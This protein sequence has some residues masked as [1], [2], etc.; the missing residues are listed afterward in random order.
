MTEDKSEGRR[1][2]PAVWEA[3]DRSDAKQ[4]ALQYQSWL[5]EALERDHDE[6]VLK[7]ARYKELPPELI[8]A[9]AAGIQ[10][11][12][13][14]LWSSELLQCAIRDHAKYAEQ[15]V[16]A[17]DLPNNPQMWL[18][19]GGGS[20]ETMR[21]GEEQFA[22][23]ARLVLPFP[24]QHLLVYLKVLH[25]LSGFSVDLHAVPILALCGMLHA[26]ELVARNTGGEMFS[27]LRYLNETIEAER[28]VA[29]L[30]RDP[31]K[32]EKT[33]S[34]GTGIR[35]NVL[36]EIVS[37]PGTDAVQAPRQAHYRY[38]V[39]S[40]MRK[41]SPLMRDPRPVRVKEYVRG[42]A[43]KPLKGRTRTV[44]LIIR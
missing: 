41:A 9:A 23:G 6:V 4:R 3:D 37:Q 18:S 35:T 7:T 28:D 24:D 14:Y 40:F 26:G 15:V 33:P 21:L 5:A 1:L 13:P 27:C 17:G 38:R 34:E 22:V 29:L 11:T 44:H 25:P 43:D 2:A 42:P 12:D 30:P 31:C 39:R 19:F 36:R 16:E 8:R 20:A 32:A 10:D